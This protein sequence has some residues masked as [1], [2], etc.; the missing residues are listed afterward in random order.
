MNKEERE[1][2]LLPPDWWNRLAS[3]YSSPNVPARADHVTDR[4]EEERGGAD[5]GEFGT[6]FMPFLYF[7][8]C[9]RLRSLN[10]YT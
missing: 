5:V 8:N 1:L 3:L 10:S 7:D 4:G 2:P 6:E 9:E